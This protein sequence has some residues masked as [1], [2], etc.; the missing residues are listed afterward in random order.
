MLVIDN[1]D[2]FT[3]NLVQ[4]LGE[5]GV[6]CTSLRNDAK[7]VDAIL[8]QNPSA[9]ILSPGPGRPQ[10]AGVCLELI[11]RSPP[12]LPIFGV[13]LGF[14]AIGEAFGGKIAAAP[15]IMHGKLS[16]IRHDG[17]ALFA[18]VPSPF[19]ATRYHS[20]MLAPQSLPACLAVTAQSDGLVMALAHKTRPIF[21]VQFHPESIATAAGY[22][23]L[24]NFCRLAGLKPK[25]PPSARAHAESLLPPKLGARRSA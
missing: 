13:C 4:F 14:Q 23:L 7:S 15:K 22:Q 18:R 11:R 20:L 17:S 16:A 6:A 3:F 9:L 19:L 8:A 12:H 2:S 24:A 10:N 21:G 1:Y 25:A 5:L